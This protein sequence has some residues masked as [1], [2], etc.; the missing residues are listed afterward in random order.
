MENFGQ[1][2]QDVSTLNDKKIE[3]VVAGD[4]NLDLKK[5]TLIINA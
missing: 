4:F 2:L 5:L 3:F 1:A